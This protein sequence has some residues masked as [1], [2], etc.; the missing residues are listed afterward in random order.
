VVEVDGSTEE[1]VHQ[2]NYKCE[3]ES[4]HA[5]LW[6]IV[7]AYG[8]Q[9]DSWG[10]RNIDVSIKAGRKYECTFTYAGVKVV[11]DEPTDEAGSYAQELMNEVHFFKRWEIP[12]DY[13]TIHNGV[14]KGHERRKT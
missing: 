10:P 12:L 5:F 3:V 2:G 11:A 9:R 7:D 13:I 1:L 14:V 4:F 8:P 6:E